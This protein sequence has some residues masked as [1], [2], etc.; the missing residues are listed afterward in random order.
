M[1]GA[2]GEVIDC[3]GNGLGSNKIMRNDS[4]VLSDARREIVYRNG[5]MS[6]A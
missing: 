6:T 4:D 1:G 2:E 5:C 3:G